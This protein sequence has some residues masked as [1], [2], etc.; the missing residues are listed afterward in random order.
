MTVPSSPRIRRYLT[1]VLRWLF[2]A[3]STFILVLWGGL[4]VTDHLLTKVYTAKAEIQLAPRFCSPTPRVFNPTTNAPFQGEVETIQSSDFLLPIIHELSLDKAWA[5]RI[6]KSKEDQLTDQ[7]ALD[8]M[9]KIL[10]LEFLRGAN[11]INITASS[12]LPHEA[13]D[14]ANAVADRYKTMREVE[15][16][17]RSNEGIDA[18]KD[19]IAQQEKSVADK[20]AALGKIAQSQSTAYLN[21]Q[22]DLDQQ[23]CLLDVMNTRLRQDDSD[24]PLQQSPVQIIC[25]AV[26]P[27]YPTRPNRTFCLV[28]T[29]VVAGL[30]SVMAGSFVEL[31]FLFQRAGEGQEI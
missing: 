3:V 9:Q 16:F 26:T 18:L 2:V 22:R 24:P 28:V 8:Y 6:Y 14:I 5:Q 1:V 10:K 31:I 11:I 13:A 21:A 20:K 17:Q 15:E 12:D 7:E 4:Y 29:T 25:R 19:Q 30:L 27:E 23:Q